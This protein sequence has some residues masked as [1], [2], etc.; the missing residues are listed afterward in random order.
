MITE[1]SERLSNF[2]TDL[3]IAISKSFNVQSLNSDYLLLKEVIEIY[4]KNPSI[5][6]RELFEKWCEVD[7]KRIFQ[8]INYLI[9][10]DDNWQEA[11]LQLLPELCVTI[12]SLCMIADE[13]EL[14]RNDLI[15]DLIE[16]PKE[17]KCSNDS[18]LNLPRE[19]DTNRARK[20][21][22]RAIEAGFIID[23]ETGYKW[24]MGEARGTIAR[25][26]YFVEKVYCPTNTE[27]LPEK[28]INDLFGVSRI[29][30]AITQL[31][32]ARKPQKWRAEIDEKIFYD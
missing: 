3:D 10:Q 28:A 1:L 19:L 15:T 4:N 8:L 30:S 11:S 7:T 31:H 9:S 16:K 2:V 29:G 18:G 23:I 13:I 17:T 26:G 5:L 21:F 12:N 20:Y 24:I 25:L 14:R 6:H 22:A 32:N 27:S